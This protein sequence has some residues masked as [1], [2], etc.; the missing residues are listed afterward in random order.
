MS[1]QRMTISGSIA[2]SAEERAESVA[3]NAVAL[4]LEVLELDERLLDAAHAL[5]VVAGDASCSQA[6]TMTAHCSTAWR[7]GISTP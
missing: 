5:E 4:V 7:V 3:E 6:R 2:S 1:F